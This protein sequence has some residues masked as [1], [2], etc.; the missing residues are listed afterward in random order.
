L[1][2]AS[3]NDGPGGRGFGV[4]PTRPSGQYSA[5]APRDPKSVGA[6]VSSRLSAARKRVG[7]RAVDAYWDRVGPIA[8]RHF[9]RYFD[10]REAWATTHWLGVQL[11]KLPNDL[12]VYQEIMHELQ[13]ALVV[14]TGTFRGGSA[15]YMASI[16]DLLGHGNVVT[17]EL[18][19]RDNLPEH[20]RIEYL[21]GSSTAPEIVERI[22]ARAADADGP[23]LVVLDSYHGR[24]HVIGELEAYHSL[25]TP[26]SYL[27]VEDTAHNGHP[28]KKGWGPGPWEAVEV[29]LAEHPEFV[30]DRARERYLH[31]SDPRGFLRRS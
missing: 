20:P 16:M 15:L 21:V 11:F 23:V 4:T 26:G 5:V 1:P 10:H 28:I 14:E 8:G 22:R 24:D 6:K 17:V 12:W 19:E 31:T 2:E 25:V 13:P 29:F 27:I 3:P 7:A 18:N 30:P 9:A